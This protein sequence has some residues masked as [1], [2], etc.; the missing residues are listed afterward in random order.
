MLSHSHKAQR[1]HAG[2]KNCHEAHAWANPMY[3][4][5]VSS[6]AAYS[7]LSDSHHAAAFDRPSHLSLRIASDSRLRA[8]QSRRDAEGSRGY[9]GA[10]GIIF[11]NIT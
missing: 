6:S 1:A 8:R 9:A 2:A 11:L 7:T 10:P 3:V 5:V 4:F